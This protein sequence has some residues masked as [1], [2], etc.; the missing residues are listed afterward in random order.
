M[1]RTGFK[2]YLD[3]LLDAR[4]KY[5]VYRRIP[6]ILYV[7]CIGGKTDVL[8]KNLDGL[9]NKPFKEF[10]KKDWETI[11]FI[12]IINQIVLKNNG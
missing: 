9:L 2:E 8:V 7:E 11:Q 12:K 1:G 3:F 5:E 10:T 6:P 4:I